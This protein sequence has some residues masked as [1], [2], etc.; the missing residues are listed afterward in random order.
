MSHNYIIYKIT[1]VESGKSYIGK[2]RRS[3]YSRWK[4]HCK[5][6]FN[7]SPLN[8]AIKSLGKDSFIREEICCPLNDELIDELERYL[9]SQFDT[10]SPGG[11]NLS[12]GGPGSPGYKMTQEQKEKIRKSKMGNKCRLGIKA[13]EYGVQRS[14]RGRPLTDSHKEKLKEAWV[15]RRGVL[16]GS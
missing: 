12:L 5:N 16:L 4:Y 1:E 15:N 7:P 9:I 6:Q 2:T 8:S 14:H 13:K 10:L 3:L 11:Y